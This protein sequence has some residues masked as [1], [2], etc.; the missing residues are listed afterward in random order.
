MPRLG[1]DIRLTESVWL[2]PSS[3][4]SFAMRL[5]LLL[6]EKLNLNGSPYHP[7]N[8]VDEEVYHLQWS[9]GSAVTQN[10]D[11][12][13]LPSIEDARY[14]FNTV[15]FHISPVYRLIDEADFVAKMEAFYWE[16][17][18]VE[19]A[20]QCRLWFVQ[21]LLVL[22]MGKA[23]LSQSKSKTEPPGSKF[24]KRAMS[25]MPDH[26]SLWKDSLMAIDVLAL[27][28]LYLYCI[29]QRESGHVYVRTPLLNSSITVYLC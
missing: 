15:K 17:N 9:V 14:L 4:W 28:G 16:N 5:T 7:P 2:A 18:A 1:S 12:T 27:A 24:F 19:K 29:D 20:N 26:G 11:V 23:F 21:F 6:I 3:P 22:S 8:F 13:G 25:L 10:P